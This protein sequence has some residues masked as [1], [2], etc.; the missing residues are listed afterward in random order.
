MEVS[1]VDL[2][3]KHQA[4]RS[5]LHFLLERGP[6]KVTGGLKDSLSTFTN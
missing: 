4:C 6:K 3:K 1:L 2:T 5:G